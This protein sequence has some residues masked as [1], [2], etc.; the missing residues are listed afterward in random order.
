MSSKVLVSTIEMKRNNWHDGGFFEAK[1][2]A[3]KVDA[4][5]LSSL[6][7]VYECVLE[8]PGPECE[9][10][11][12]TIEMKR[13]E[14]SGGCKVITNMTRGCE[15]CNKYFCKTCYEARIVG[16]KE[17]E[18]GYEHIEGTCTIYKNNA[19]ARCSERF[20]GERCTADQSGD[21]CGAGHRWIPTGEPI[22]KLVHTAWSEEKEP[23]GM[24]VTKNGGRMLHYR[25]HR[26]L[27]T[28]KNLDS[29]EFQELYHDGVCASPR[30]DKCRKANE[31]NYRKCSACNGPW[32]DK[33]VN[34]IQDLVRWN[35]RRL[36]K[37]TTSADAKSRY[38][39]SKPYR[40]AN[41]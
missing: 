32:E 3:G 35:T 7:Y 5:K 11:I 14:C 34:A 12:Q 15:S 38:T 22:A 17:V 4:E 26:C 31:V 30:D 28:W 1:T 2:F 25:E 37:V 33:F 10:S 27:L 41:E 40:Y 19:A 16:R 9:K 36:P 20:T 24:F 13:D 39:Y 6:Q 23:K 18:Y 8:C 21:L 29:G